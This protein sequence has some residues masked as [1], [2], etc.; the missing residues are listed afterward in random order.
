MRLFTVHI[1]ALSAAADG[2]AQFVP[3][4]FSWA[5][6]L[7]PVIWALWHRLWW[8]ALA[9]LAA[10]AAIGALIAP[11]AADPL[12]QSV[13]PVAAQLLFGVLANDWRRAILRRRGLV[14]TALVAAPDR[15]AAEHRYFQSRFDRLLPPR[16]SAL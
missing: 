16:R 11:L 8:L 15:M 14:E 7:L 10:Q 5:A 9:L 1:Q 3:Q 6:F 4:G 12:S 13:I 2:E